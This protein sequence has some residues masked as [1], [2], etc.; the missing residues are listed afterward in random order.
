MAQLGPA[1]TDTLLIKLNVGLLLGTVGGLAAARP[2]IDR[3]PEVV[4]GFTAQLG[5]PEHPRTKIQL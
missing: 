1:H 5:P 3:G 4:A 2:P